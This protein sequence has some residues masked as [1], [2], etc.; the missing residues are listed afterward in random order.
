MEDF[1]FIIISIVL[2]MFFWMVKFKNL[3]KFIIKFIIKFNLKSKLESIVEFNDSK[4][5]RYFFKTF[6][7]GGVI[8]FTVINLFT[9]KLIWLKYE[10]STK[11]LYISTA[12]FLILMCLTLLF[13]HLIFK[14]LFFPNNNNNNQNPPFTIV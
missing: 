2:P 5:G 1:K 12:T 9:S 11:G 14:D 8:S 10:L 7:I 4:A 6:A 13:F 3:L